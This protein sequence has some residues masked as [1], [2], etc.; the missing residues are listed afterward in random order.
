MMMAKEADLE[1]FETGLRGESLRPASY[2]YEE[3]R[4]FWNGMIDSK[5]ALIAR[6]TGVADVIETVNDQYTVEE[7]WS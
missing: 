5:P 2:G 6:C 7:F 4:E 1:S 3:A